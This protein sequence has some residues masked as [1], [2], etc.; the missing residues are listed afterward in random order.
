MRRLFIILAALTL[1]APA[2]KTPQEKYIEK[3]SDLAVSEMKRS[4]VPASITLAQG[5]IESSYGNSPLAKKG[6]N[7]FG[8]KCHKDWKGKKMYHDDDAAHECFRMYASVEQSYQDH[9]DFLRYQNRYKSLFD[10]D[11]T[12]YKGWAKGLKA[13][14]Y[15]TDP[16][17]A[18]KLIRLIEEYDLGRFDTDIVVEVEA[19]LEVERPKKVEE[20]VASMGRVRYEEVVKFSLSRQVY[21]QNGT[22]FIYSIQGETYASIAEANGLF[23]KEL[24]LYND[25]S[26]NAPLETGTVVYLQRKRKY[27]EKGMDKLIIG[28]DE[29]M[30]LRDICQKY[31]VRMSSIRKLNNLPLGYVPEEGETILLR[32]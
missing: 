11:K 19:P 26:Y 8:V 20:V 6:N 23:L 5:M 13:A 21:V 10:L 3:Y 16:G 18:G 12:D 22:P 27:A 2:D 24:L 4:G 32:K 17:Y 9:S 14:G 28:P 25:L 1:L 31:A 7:H 15:A 30:T 29:D